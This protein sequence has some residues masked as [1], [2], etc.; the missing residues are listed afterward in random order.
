MKQCCEGGLTADR[1]WCWWGMVSLKVGEMPL[2]ALRLFTFCRGCKCFLYLIA[3][4]L[5]F[6]P[7]FHILL[8]SVMPWNQLYVLWRLRRYS[9][10][11]VLIA[12][13]PLV[14]S[15]ACTLKAPATILCLHSLLQLR[16]V[17]TFEASWPAFP[18][19]PEF[20]SLGCLHAM[21]WCL[22]NVSVCTLDA[23]A[24]LV[25]LLQTV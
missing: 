3:F 9:L 24:L 16:W 19:L 20:Q 10:W 2:C 14:S 11:L 17:L 5:T 21:I 13:G 25:I 7:V 18:D 12:V 23:C 22:G 15:C 1:R 4:S 8:C 6:L